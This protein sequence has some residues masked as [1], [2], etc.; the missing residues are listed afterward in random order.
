M[1]VSYPALV[2]APVDVVLRA[3]SANAV[4]DELPAKVRDHLER[5]RAGERAAPPAAL[6]PMG[7]DRAV[8][9]ADP[10]ISSYCQRFGIEPELRRLVGA[11]PTS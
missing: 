1:H 4:D 11:A 5:Q 2:Q 7:H 3:L 9:W 6:D 10:V 8:I